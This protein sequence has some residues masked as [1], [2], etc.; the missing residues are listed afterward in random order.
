MIPEQ[1]DEN[2]WRIAKKR[3]AFRKHLFT[4]M[5][6]IGFLWGVWWFT[7]G[8]SRGFSGYPWPAWIMLVWGIGL[9]LN[10]FNAFHGSGEDLAQQEYEKL[11]RERE[12]K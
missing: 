11:K 10:Y 1:R 8:R 4:Y 3:A 5:V 9:G 6:I 7:I 2:L 12:L